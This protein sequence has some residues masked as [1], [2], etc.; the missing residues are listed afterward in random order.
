MIRACLFGTYTSTHPAN[1]LLVHALNAA[2]CELSICHEPLWERTRDKMA[3]FFGG[4]SLARLGAS[5]A[6]AAAR[7]IRHWRQLPKPEL[8]VTGFNGQLDV[9]L[10]RR[11][12]G[13]RAR[14]VFAPLVTLTETLVDDRR[15]YKRGGM[16]ARLA[17]R[18]DRR[19]LRTA[20]LVLLDTEAHRAYVA[21]RLDPRCRTATLYLG[22]EPM[23]SPGPE[24]PRAAGEPLRV[25][26][27]GQY[28]PLHGAGTI[29]EAAALLGRKSGVEF[30]M[31]GT[32][33]ERAA[34]EE[35]AEARNC[36]HV[37][38]E[39]WVPYEELPDRLRQCDVALG[40]FGMTRKARMV[41]PTKVYQAAA[42]GRALITGETPAI[43][44]VFTPGTHLL[45]VPRGDPGAIAIALR[46]L[47]DNPVRRRALGEAAARLLA[48]HLDYQAQGAR[49]RTVLTE[50]FPE[51]DGTFVP[52]RSAEQRRQS[53]GIGA[54]RA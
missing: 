3:S 17:T 10:A 23:F 41:I 42:T 36:A 53:L 12:A 7:L 51:L 16:K 44:E 33:P 43:R 8:V 5:Y 30:T 47:R 40:I 20:D 46:E 39:D 15:V 34:V 52:P 11:L 27:Y 24:R 13:R 2:G 1:R 50:A 49:L 32:G 38:F 19:T 45:T 26:F 31:I 21:Q 35:R 9:L 29:V 54:S 48:E 18:L 28:V 25:L 22:A 6:I 4:R 37:R 14:L